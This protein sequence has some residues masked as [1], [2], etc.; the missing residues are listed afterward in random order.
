MGKDD[1]IKNDYWEGVAENAPKFAGDEY[2][3][4]NDGYKIGGD[5]AK[6]DTTALAS[7]VSKAGSD[8]AGFVGDGLQAAT[9]PIGYLIQSGLGFLES[10]LT[11]LKDA[12]ELVTGDPKALEQS[13]E[14]YN[15][16]ATSLNELAE[17]VEQTALSGGQG[18]GG[19]TAVAAGQ[20]IGATK[21]S[22]T[23]TAQAAGHLATLCQ[24][25][26]M[27]ME[28]A[29]DIVNGIL[30]ELIEFLVMTWLTALSLSIVTFGGSDAAAATATTVKVTEAVEQ[31]GTKVNSVREILQSIFNIIKKLWSAIKKLA[32]KLGKK[33]ADSKVGE[34]TLEKLDKPLSGLEK[35]IDKSLEKMGRRAEP[36]LA[37]EGGGGKLLKDV[38]GG[39]QAMEAKINEGGVGH[40]TW[41][42][43][44][45]NLPEQFNDAV[46]NSGK[47]AIGLP[48]D[49]KMDASGYAN[50]TEKT[51]GYISGGV[52]ATGYSDNPGGNSPNA[53]PFAPEDTSGQESPAWPQQDP[54]ERPTP[55]SEGQDSTPNAQPTPYYPSRDGGDI[56]P[57]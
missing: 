29:L 34:K 1:L 45:E 15:E 12:I 46:K 49:G 30:A 13:A 19:D 14:K 57:A 17:R 7:D 33:F 44:K 52:K 28:A 39:R 6:G 10:V 51:L 23:E 5:I 24:I 16:L 32:G 22:I 40:A 55:D 56:E 43:F 48:K 8:V 50:L 47:E 42:T 21:Q 20:N 11:P 18:W 37:K 54:D 38:K 26:G 53:N 41:G 31:T 25:S 27:L 36:F 9:D 4:F 3:L 35:N 2:K